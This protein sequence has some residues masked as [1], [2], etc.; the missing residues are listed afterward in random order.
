MA[1]ELLDTSLEQAGEDDETTEQEQPEGIDLSEL[2][3]YA[4]FDYSPEPFAE[5]S[6]DAKA[7]LLEIDSTTD[8]VD[9]AS[10]RLEV[11]QCWE[12]LH[13]D[14]GYQH[15]YRDRKGGWILPGQQMSNGKQAPAYD[16][17]QNTNIYS[18]EGD[19]IT[20]ALTI[21]VPKVEFFPINPDYAPDVKAAEQAEN[22]KSIWDLNNNLQALMSECAR[23]FW[24]EDRVL[25]Y[26]RYILNGQKFGYEDED[27]TPVVPQDEEAP[28]STEPTGQE[29]DE[30]LEEANVSVET[31]KRK[32]RGREITTAHGKLDHKVPMAV[33]TLDKMHFVKLYED[34]DISLVRAM[35][36]WIADEIQPGSD[37][38]SE[39]ELDR[40]ARENVRQAVLG[41]YVTGDSMKSH[42]VVKHSWFRPACFFG[43]KVKE[44]VRAELLEAF[45]DGC[46]L[47]KAGSEYAFSRNEGVDAHLAIGHAVTGKGQNRRSL[48]NGMIQVQKRI[49]DW[50][51]LLDSFFR[52][53]VPKKWM[54]SEAF[55][56]EAI[57][58]G[59]NIPGSTGP[60]Q[61]QP[62]L[63]TADQYI[64][65]EPTPQ[66]QPALAQF[67][68]WFSEN[69]AQNV[70]GAVPSL[71]GAAT[72]TDTL[73]GI[74]VQRDQAL[75]RI[76]PAWNS[77]QLLVSQ[78]ALQAVCCAAEC[79]DGKVLKQT[80][81]GRGIVEVNCSELKGNVS[82]KPEASPAF[83]ESWAAREKKILMLFDGAKG[84]P[85]LQK[86][87]LTP[88]NLPVLRDAIRLKNFTIPGADSVRKQQQEF[89]LLL[90]APANFNPE[91]EQL[92]ETIK[93]ATEG[94]KSVAA[95][96]QQVP[97]DAQQKL[98]QI[99]QYASTLPEKM[100]SVQVAQD[101]S[102]DHVI[103]ATICTEWM[104][105][106]EG[107]AFKYGTDK[108]KA[109]F[110]NVSLHRKEHLAMA[111][112][113]AAE[114]AP[115]QQQK[116]PSESLSANFKDMPVAIQVQ[117]LEKLG[118]KATPEDFQ[119]KQKDEA[120][121]AIV[122]KSIP[123]QIAVNKQ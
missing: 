119:Q 45:P 91:Y 36:P 8:K 18:S 66:P 2:G 103:E 105:S 13:F 28:P 55:D 96:G 67:V 22:F 44:E 64:M 107:Q 63:T 111:K 15:L 27:D 116:D 30:Q 101:D 68:Q 7:A 82:C 19:I 16:A 117:M 79:R 50:V 72:N 87:M 9:V 39:V 31:G 113:I 34:L 51:D 48:G 11:E 74:E 14:R 1:E 92:Q 12:A 47:V 114:N 23:I 100:S 95:S 86:I 102:E 25:L 78:A 83:P 120:N 61:P 122:K 4:P 76:G 108:Q 65:V 110:E 37:G 94:M 88:K 97:P 60:F 57:K 121:L 43:D 26:T 59:A 70:T 89:E 38:T 112:K 52:R 73:G 109:S 54:N 20:A 3:C 71:F 80:I 75:Q 84:N 21:E 93:G 115:P 90:R 104:N 6:E 40:I 69:I 81:P 10:R 98:Q 56:L 118:F 41:A 123:E 106:S 53:T 32:P 17:D 29:G 49:N 62:G 85:E 35:F 5:L 42:V 46:L 99:Q 24:N 58:T 77:L 33:D